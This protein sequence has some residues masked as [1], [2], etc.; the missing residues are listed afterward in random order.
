VEGE[1]QEQPVV[2]EQ[3]EMEAVGDGCMSPELVGPAP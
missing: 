1:Q 2:V 3:L